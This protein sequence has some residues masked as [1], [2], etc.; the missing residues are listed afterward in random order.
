MIFANPIKTPY[1]L[2]Y[3]RNKDVKLLSFDNKEELLK[4]KNSH[5]DAECILRISTNTEKFG[6][7]PEDAEDLLITA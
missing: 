2:N 7:D 5:P 3:A 1:Q 6:V 4:I